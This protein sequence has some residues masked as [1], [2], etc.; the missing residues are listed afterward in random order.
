MYNYRV[1]SIDSGCQTFYKRSEDKECWIL[2]DSK[3]EYSVVYYANEFQFIKIKDNKELE[4]K[5]API[6]TKD[7]RLFY[8]KICTLLRQNQIFELN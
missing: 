2:I 8:K 3:I 1:T 5:Q 7:N 6:Y 4:S